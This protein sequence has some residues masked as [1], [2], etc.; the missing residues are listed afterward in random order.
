ERTTYTFSSGTSPEFSYQAV[1]PALYLEN[2]VRYTLSSVTAAIYLL[3]QTASPDLRAGF[4]L[5]VDGASVR[6]RAFGASMLA[7]FALLII[8][9]MRVIFASAEN[10]AAV[11][12][13]AVTVLFIAD[14]DEKALSFFVTV[15]QEW[16]LFWLMN[17]LSLSLTLALAG[18]VYLGNSDVLAEYYWNSKI[19]V[20]FFLAVS[21]AVLMFLAFTLSRLLGALCE[22][23][24][25]D[26]GAG[27]EMWLRKVVRKGIGGAINAVRNEPC[28]Y[29][30]LCVW[31]CVAVSTATFDPEDS[32]DFSWTLSYFAV[33]G[34][35]GEV[36]IA[37][38]IREV[39]AANFSLAA[40]LVMLMF[41]KW[42][43]RAWATR[44]VP[45]PLPS[46]SRRAES[47]QA[48]LGHDNQTDHLD[49]PTHQQRRS[50]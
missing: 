2:D 11:I 23:R 14:L 27:R 24:D 39:V 46:F 38:S 22:A 20:W 32:P 7:V 16:R 31:F 37:D 49:S 50:R 40:G 42:Q 35:D 19:P 44:S 6:Y 12:A 41:R 3:V 43:D 30:V 9:A 15:P 17:I 33:Y 1:T 21:P 45:G 25:N 10:N 5:L 26:G 29:A 47:T 34:E 18:V 8:A 13:E 4:S 48:A 28:F 36:E